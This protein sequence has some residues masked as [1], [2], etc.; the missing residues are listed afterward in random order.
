MQALVQSLM[1]QFD[2]VVLDSPPAIPFSDARILSS[3]V[4]AVILV[5]RYGVSTRR[6]MQRCAALFEEIH[7]PVFGFVL[8][9]IDHASADL[10]YY[11]YGYGRAMTAGLTKRSLPDDQ[12]SQDSTQGPQDKSTSAHA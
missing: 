2:Y 4:D 10:D 1:K 11:N 9:D 12:H 8:N 5:G 7:A 3:V 6:S